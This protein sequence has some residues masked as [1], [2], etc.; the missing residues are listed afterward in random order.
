MFN[1]P[2]LDLIILLAFTYFM[3]SLLLSTINESVSNGLFRLRQNGLKDALEMLFLKPEW[4]TF[5][6]GQ[7]IKSPHIQ[8]LMRDAKKYPAYIPANNFILA[9]IQMIGSKNYIQG[10]LQNAIA[11]ATLPDD[12]KQVLQD[13]AAKADN[14]LENFEKG[15]ARFYDDAMDRAGGWYKKRIRLILLLL[16]FTLSAAL[17]LDTLKI[18]DD[19]LNNKQ[20]QKE[21]IDKIVAQLPNIRMDRDSLTTTVTIKD[22]EGKILVSQKASLDTAVDRTPGSKSAKASL[23]SFHTIQLMY[24][25]TSALSLGYKGWADAQS[26]WTGT[27]GKTWF[28]RLG[29]FIKKLLGVLITAFALQLGSNYWFDMLNKAVNIRAVGKKP[30]ENKK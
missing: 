16:G 10:N 3:G 22:A 28:E 18:A 23:E 25:N 8:S 4:K 5:V 15:L 6:Q 24:E 1:S 17:N 20:H 11:S 27:H 7:F 14:K 13:I 9:V 19:A 21:T 2:I 12:F 29:A 30:E 26:Q